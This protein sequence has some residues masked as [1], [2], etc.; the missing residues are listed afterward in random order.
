MIIVPW[1]GDLLL[2]ISVW[3]LGNKCKDGWLFSL[4]GNLCWLSY[5]ISETIWA[6]VFISSVMV[7]L[8]ICNWRKWN[9]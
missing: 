6:A 9:V 3:R 4:V 2:L 8:A 1:T 7:A 5:G